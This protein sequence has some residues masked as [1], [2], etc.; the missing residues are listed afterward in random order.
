MSKTVSG[1]PQ[2]PF[3]RGLCENKGPGTSSQVAFFVKSFDDTFLLLYY[4]Y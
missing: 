3:Y 2:I 4:I 1:L